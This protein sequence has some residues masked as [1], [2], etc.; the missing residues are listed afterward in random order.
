MY[1]VHC[2]HCILKHRYPLPLKLKQQSWKKSENLKL[3]K[4]NKEKNV[5][6]KKS[7]DLLLEVLYLLSKVQFR[8]AVWAMVSVAI[9]YIYDIECK[10]APPPP[11]SCQ[12]SAS[13]I[14]LCLYYPIVQKQQQHSPRV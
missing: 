14:L 4:E 6:E 9:L 11:F 3:V 12:N 13:I 5:N 2:T 8:P 7:L 1:N 10:T